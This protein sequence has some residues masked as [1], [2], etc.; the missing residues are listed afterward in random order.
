MTRHG[1][2]ILDILSIRKVYNGL[3]L[4]KQDKSNA[5]WEQTGVGVIPYLLFETEFY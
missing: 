2:S 4:G 1:V 3:G 5:S